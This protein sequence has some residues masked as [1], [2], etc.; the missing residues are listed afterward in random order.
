M[1]PAPDTV[2]VVVPLQTAA[3]AAA[4]AATAPV[5]VL[6]IGN[7]PQPGDGA[8]YHLRE[9]SWYCSLC[10]KEATEGHIFSWHHVK[11]MTYIGAKL[12]PW[13]VKLVRENWGYEYYPRCEEVGPTQQPPPPPA[14][15]TGDEARDV[16][17]QPPPPP[18][19]LTARDVARDVAQ[20]LAEMRRHF[21]SQ[22]DERAAEFNE[23][24]AKVAILEISCAEREGYSLGSQQPGQPTATVGT[25]ADSLLPTGHGAA[26][27]SQQPGQPAATVGTAAGLLAAAASQPLGQPTATVDTASD[28]WSSGWEAWSSSAGAATWQPAGAAEAGGDGGA[29]ARDEGIAW[30]QWEQW[31]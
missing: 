19:P 23:L 3:A 28:Q 2:M 26:A 12:Q 5:P 7:Y 18:A 8:P 11:Q 9:G 17:Q 27:G 31:R 1:L 13:A 10:N 20:Q 25:V 24:A 22:F 4:A 15:L 30:G 16:A 6:A 14:P 29:A 21:Q